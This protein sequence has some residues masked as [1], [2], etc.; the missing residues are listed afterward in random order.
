MLR[1][2]SGRDSDPISD[3]EADAPQLGEQLLGDGR[4]QLADDLLFLRAA[5]SS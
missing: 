3:V 1:K 2:V 5:C 4:I